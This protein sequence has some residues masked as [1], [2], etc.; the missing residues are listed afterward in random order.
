MLAVKG[1]YENGKVILENKPLI[2]MSEVIV[3]FPNQESGKALDELTL[4]QRKEL[5]D[6]FSGSVNRIIDWKAERIIKPRNPF[7]L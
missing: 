3:V 1:I 4:E 2:E 6:D 5:F 7:I